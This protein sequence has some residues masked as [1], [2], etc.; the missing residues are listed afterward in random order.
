MG[1]VTV[2][3]VIGVLVALLPSLILLLLMWLDP[4]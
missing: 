1:S 4:T 3:F 2:C